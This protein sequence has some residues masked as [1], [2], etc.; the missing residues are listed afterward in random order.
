MR[1]V[2]DTNVLIPGIF[3][4]GTL[5][6]LVDACFIGDPELVAEAV[7]A[8]PDDDK[9][10]ACAISGGA[11]V[12]ASDDEHLHA[13]SGYAGIEVLDPREVVDRYRI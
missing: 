12:I 2:V 1:I 4:S 10:T 5:S 8:D 11:K 7:C 13:V 9:F 6:V 3:F